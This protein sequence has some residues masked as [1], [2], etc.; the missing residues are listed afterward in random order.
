VPPPGFSLVRVRS[1]IEPF[2]G[3]DG[4]VYQL[5]REDLAVIPSRNA[6]VLNERKIVA[7]IDLPVP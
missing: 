6:D 4:R 2:M 7:T 1:E 3:V 5:A